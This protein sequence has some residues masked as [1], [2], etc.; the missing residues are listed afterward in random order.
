MKRKCLY[1]A[2]FLLFLAAGV[3]LLYPKG[4]EVLH[5]FQD[6]KQ[7]EDFQQQAE[8]AEDSRELLSRMEAYNQRLTEEGQKEISDA[9]SYGGDAFQ[10]EDS[11]LE[12]GMIGYLTIP[13]MEVELPLY[14]GASEENLQK[15]AAV[16]VETS[17]PVGGAS[18]NCVI[19]GH[20]GYKGI[21]MFREIEALQPGDRIKITN[22]WETLEYEVVKFIVTSPDDVQVIKIVP[23]A[24]LVTLITCHPYTLNY[25]RYVVFCVR[26]QEGEEPEEEQKTEGQQEEENAREIPEIA[27]Y[28]SLPYESSREEIRREKTLNCGGLA[29]YTAAGILLLLSFLVR[30]KKAGR[31]PHG[32]GME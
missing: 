15:G 24:D 8:T 6:K 32:R 3:F 11:G 12:E 23:G 18:T 10:M 27:G 25:E 1:A 26:V 31:K 13:A 30:R 22:P 5:A 4:Q 16:L 19:A 9:W 7:I 14:V 21:P 20:R 28:Q 2:A 29:V 17:M